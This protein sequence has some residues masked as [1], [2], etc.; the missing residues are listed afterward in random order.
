MTGPSAQQSSPP[1]IAE[2]MAAVSS[3]VDSF[4]ELA[5]SIPDPD[6]EVVTTPGWSITDVLGHVTMEPSRYR[7]LALGRGAWPS[8]VIDLPAF[9]AHQ[10]RALPTRDMNELADKLRSD[11]SELL[12]AVSA[13]GDDPPMMHFDGDKRVRADRAL[14]TLLGEFVVHGYDIARTAHRRWNIAPTLVPLIM[15]GVNQSLPGWVDSVRTDGH[16]AVY[17]L[18]LRGLTRYVYS[19]HEGRLT[20]NPSHPGRIDAH[21]SA[22]PVTALLMNYGRIGQLRATYSRKPPGVGSPTV[23]GAAAAR[24]ISSRLSCHHGGK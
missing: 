12:A 24:P 6:I 16:T 20:V 1:T 8:R 7:E 9:N 21:I 23:A 15:E 5:L 13:F 19:F 3:A 17:E 2:L 22:E 18:R 11:T 10:I 4:S 14:G